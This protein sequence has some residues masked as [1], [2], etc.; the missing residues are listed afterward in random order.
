MS[1]TRVTEKFLQRLFAWH[2]GGGS[3]TYALASSLY[4]RKYHRSKVTITQAM[5][6]ACA[7]ELS[8][9]LTGNYTK[10]ER[11]D[12]ALLARQVRNLKPSV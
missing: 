9:P 5:I 6:D 4:S 12:L 11:A 2:S 10:Q 3:P 7:K 1:H 8:K